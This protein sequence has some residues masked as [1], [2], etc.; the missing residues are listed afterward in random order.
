M[1][2]SDVYDDD[3]DDN[4][5]GDDSNISNIQVSQS[6]VCLVWCVPSRQEARIRHSILLDFFLLFFILFIRCDDNL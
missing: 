5:D 1:A 3:D 4:G 6:S 2:T